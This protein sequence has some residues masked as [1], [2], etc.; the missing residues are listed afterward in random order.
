[1]QIIAPQ[2]GLGQAC[3]AVLEALPDWFGIPESNDEYVAF[4]EAHPTWSA[5]DN[6]GQVVGLL[7]PH[8]HAESAEIHLIAVLPQWHRYGVGRALVDA[9]E[10]DSVGRGFR[11]AQ[12]KTL[13]PSDPD[14]GYALTRQFYASLGYLQLEEMLDLWPGNP[15]L[16]MVK[17]LAMPAGEAAA[18]ARSTTPTTTSMIVSALRSAGVREGS[19]II[20]HSSLSGIGW[21]AGA[22][23]AV[24]EALLAV[25]GEHGTIVMPAHTSLSDPATWVNPPVPEDWWP[26]IRDA[27]P[28]FDPALS[29]T[30]GMGRVVESFRRLPGVRH[31][32]HPS[33]AFVARGP[34]ADEIVGR[35]PLAQALN[36]LSPLGRLYEYDASIVL[37]GVGHASNTS[38]H[39]AEHRANYS[40]KRMIPQS[41][42]M[43]V[44]GVRQW[45][46]YDDLDLN[47]TDFPQIGEAFA[48]AGGDEARVP[49]GDG[50]V[51]SCSMR[52]IVDFAVGWM[53]Q[54]RRS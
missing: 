36:D 38:L 7:A 27:H 25:V 37:L 16:V 15:A 1:M 39:L 50:E 13:G 33:V 8:H 29:A 26:V 41:A 42:P 5:V 20:V 28:A 11:L 18:I 30:R 32:G 43:L 4:V 21:V 34:R 3:R 17:P 31:S 35:H 22:A 24:I 12:V 9:F 51:T 6:D 23:Q 48:S 10:T 44:D 19:V 53:E 40:G 54:H 2:A 45:V 52:D 47:E 14:A 46:T 49:V